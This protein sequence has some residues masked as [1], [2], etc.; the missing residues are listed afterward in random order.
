MTLSFAKLYV[1]CNPLLDVLATVSGDFMAKYKL[2]PGSA[3]LL[4]PETSEI[5][6]DLEK[7]PDV[8]YI[9]GGSG[10]NTAR[11]AQWLLGAP[12]GQFVTYVGCISDD[13]YG[14]ILR[15]S[16]EKDGVNMMLEYTTKEST[17]SCAVCI[18][19]KE[20]SLVANLAAANCLS[21]QHV[22]STEVQKY[23]AEAD[24]FYLT[25]FTLTID[26]EY[27]LKV[28]KIANEKGGVF[29]LNLS[30]PFILE[31]FAEQLNK[32]LPY[33]RI[34]F[35]NEMEANALAKVWGWDTADLAEIARLALANLPYACEKERIFIITHGAKPTIWATI[36]GV[37]EVPV[38][39]IEQEKILDLNGAGDAFV[40]GFLAAY[41]LGKDITTCC[42]AGHYSAGVVIQHDGC[43]YPEKPNFSLFENH[44]LAK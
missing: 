28:A 15:E 24:L 40:G 13:R 42:V 4:T 16:S 37:T 41:A 44:N 26:V 21:S 17:G 29:M 34:V 1:Q 31:F 10:L 39:P 30:A 23:R 20:R 27:V 5:F 32:V 18:F 36:D 6:N 3:T 14:T 9:P 11:V 19:H 22:F 2:V 38:D 8:K 7:L 12:K 43:T 33:V 35:C 25:G